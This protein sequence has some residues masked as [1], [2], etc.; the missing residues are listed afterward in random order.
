MWVHMSPIEY[1]SMHEF[2]LEVH[3]SHF[4]SMNTLT[5][6]LLS[7]GLKEVSH[8]ATLIVQDTHHLL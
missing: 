7:Y 1:Y 8:V 3:C 2:E 5:L 6:Y 4:L